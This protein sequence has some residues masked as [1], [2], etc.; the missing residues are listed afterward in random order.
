MGYTL[1]L[2]QKHSRAYTR[3]CPLWGDILV[4]VLL[5]CR[6]YLLDSLL[7]ILLEFRALLDLLLERLITEL[8]LGW[9]RESLLYGRTGI[10]PLPPLEQIGEL[11]L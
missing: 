7:E 4:S 10:D 6:I 8:A 1:L 5:L 11:L 3:V 2:I 9:Y